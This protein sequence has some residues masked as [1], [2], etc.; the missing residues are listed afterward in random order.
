[1][2][3]NENEFIGNGIVKVCYLEEGQRL[4]ELGELP[5]V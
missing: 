2:R 4:S 1:M 5:M 3:L